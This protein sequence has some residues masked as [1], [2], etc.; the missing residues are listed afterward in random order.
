MRKPFLSLLSLAVCNLLTVA[1]KRLVSEGH[2]Q[3]IVVKTLFLVELQCDDLFLLQKC[4]FC[5]ILSS[6]AVLW[7][8]ISMTDLWW[9]QWKFSILI[10][11]HK[12]HGT[13]IGKIS[14]LYCIKLKVSLFSSLKCLML[15]CEQNIRKHLDFKILSPLERGVNCKQNPHNKFSPHWECFRTTWWKFKVQ[16]CNR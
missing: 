12:Y 4:L 7:V 13:G 6:L 3:I 5:E 11:T 16:I 8:V 9:W 2:G 14:V 1:Q 15:N 10:Q